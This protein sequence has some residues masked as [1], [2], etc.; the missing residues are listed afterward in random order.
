M[1]Q[2]HKNKPDI[3]DFWLANKIFRN[4]LCVYAF[5]YYHISSFTSASLP[6]IT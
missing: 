3:P 6:I 4:N 5:M 2:N 1:I